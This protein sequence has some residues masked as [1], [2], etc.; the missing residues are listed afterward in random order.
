MERP[1]S[2]LKTLAVAMLII[3]FIAEL[4]GVALLAT[5][6]SV[7]SAMSV[8]IPGLVLVMLGVIFIGQGRRNG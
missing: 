1:S 7:P 3:G 6:R 5:G 2:E 4:V 8:M